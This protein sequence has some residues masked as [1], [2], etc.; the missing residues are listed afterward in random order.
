MPFAKFKVILSRGA[1]SDLSEIAD[2]LQT[3]RS[4]KYA[5]LFLDQIDGALD[6]L[7]Q[8]PERGALVREISDFIDWK[9]RQLIFYPYRVIYYIEGKTVYIATILDGRRDIKS[10]LQKRLIG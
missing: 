7:E 1:K 2:Y 9:F 4:I 8:F 10:I 6:S 3:N 5:S